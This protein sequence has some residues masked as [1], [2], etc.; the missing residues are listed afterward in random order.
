TIQDLAYS[1]D[2]AGLVTQTTSPFADESWTY[3]YDDLHR[4]TSA[5]TQPNGQNSQT[6]AYDIVGNVTN[7]SLIGSYSYPAPGSARPHA[8]SA[9]GADPFSYDPNGNLTAGR[10][11]T[12]QWNADNLPSAI[13]ATQMTYDGLGE[14]LKKATGSATSLYPLGH[15]DEITKGVIRKCLSVGALGIVA[16]RVGAQTFWI[17]TD[18]LGS[19]QAI[20]DATGASVQRRT[21]RPY[22]DKIAD[23]TSHSESRGYIGER[24]D[25]E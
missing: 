8:P 23:A 5:T 7:N 6:F 13:N 11:R 1:P 22:G 10:G 15:D 24:Q 14:R 12:I 25:S 2:A 19:I 20:T 18:R 17:H 9:L 21:Y 16:K 3:G 4:L